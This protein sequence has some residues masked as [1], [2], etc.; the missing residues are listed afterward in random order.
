MTKKRGLKRAEARLGHDQMDWLDNHSAE[1]GISKS[2]L[3]QLAVEQFITQKQSMS[4]L[5]EMNELLHK[6]EKHLDDEKS[7]K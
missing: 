3:I 7:E 6:L 1:T 5:V 4:T 2:S